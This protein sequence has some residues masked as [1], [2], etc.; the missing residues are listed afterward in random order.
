VDVWAALP[1]SVADRVKVLA[2][3]GGWSG[4][5]GNHR[6]ITETMQALGI[7]DGR[8]AVVL[9]AVREAKAQEDLPFAPWVTLVLDGQI[10]RVPVT[11][12]SAQIGPV[13]GS[14]PLPR[15]RK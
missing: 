2:S 3:E 10:T 1:P 8:R 7:V 12:P 13:A 6:K 15:G 9:R 5:F 4:I 11:N 14:A